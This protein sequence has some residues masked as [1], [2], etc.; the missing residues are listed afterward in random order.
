MEWFK[1]L[2]NIILNLKK[3]IFFKWKAGTFLLQN[4]TNRHIFKSMFTYILTFIS[5]WYYFKSIK[6]DLH[7]PN[8]FLWAFNIISKMFVIL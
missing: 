1:K 6:L 7:L 3:K 8:D 5:K 2:F 4:S